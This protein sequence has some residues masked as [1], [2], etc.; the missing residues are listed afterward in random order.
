MSTRANHI[1]Q[2]RQNKQVDAQQACA[3]VPVVPPDAL[4]TLIANLPGKRSQTNDDGDGR[5]G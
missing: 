5:S 2:E 3:E 1:L 4:T